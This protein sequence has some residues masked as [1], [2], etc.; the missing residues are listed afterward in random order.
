MNLRDDDSQTDFDANLD[1]EIDNSESDSS[2]DL[3]QDLRGDDGSKVVS[4]SDDFVTVSTDWD[5][6]LDD[7]L[8]GELDELN[9]VNDPADDSGFFTADSIV[10]DDFDD[11]DDLD[12]ENSDQPTDVQS[13]D[14][15]NHREAGN[16]Q[17]RNA[18]EMTSPGVDPVRVD[19]AAKPQSTNEPAIGSTESADRKGAASD[20]RSVFSRFRGWFK[21]TKPK[22]ADDKPPVENVA[23]DSVPEPAA[24]IETF[25]EFSESIGED[26]NFG[27]SSTIDIASTPTEEVSRLDA[28]TYF[29]NLK[30]VTPGEPVWDAL[31]TEPVQNSGNVDPAAAVF[32]LDQPSSTPANATENQEQSESESAE[33]FDY[34]TDAVLDHEIEVLSKTRTDNSMTRE[35]DASPPITQSPA[36]TEKG[37]FDPTKPTATD[38]L[39]DPDLRYSL[40]NE[41]PD[42]GFAHSDAMVPEDGEFPDEAT[43]EISDPSS[44]KPLF[45]S[46]AD[47]IREV[48]PLAIDPALQNERFSTLQSQIDELERENQLLNNSLLAAN[49]ELERIEPLKAETIRLGQRCDVSQKKHVELESQLES[50]KRELELS[51]VKTTEAIQQF[52]DQSNQREE[53]QTRL[54]GLVIE[55][56]SLAEEL[57]TARLELADRPPAD[58]PLAVTDPEFQR[59]FEL[60]LKQEYKKRRQAERELAQA[61]EQRNELAK[62]LAAARRELRAAQSTRSPSNK[63]DEGP[64]KK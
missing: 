40:Q 61:E 10:P 31:T 30:T 7:E 12:F 50:L 58:H 39:Y 56:Q 16:K 22:Q 24:S 6:E 41:L 3:G 23:K 8:N 35:P 37:D 34:S 62:V 51:Q 38:T 49:K 27:Q 55:N 53:L 15:G 59:R 2:L 63:T 20:R 18:A 60:R 43:L 44:P 57:E 28:G 33:E 13:A 9:F 11:F 5:H 14:A 45:P 17:G 36:E 47:T 4:G 54:D 25:N 26:F 46:A 32:N 64:G 29:D 21:S 42:P 1:S 48:G 52:N 19:P